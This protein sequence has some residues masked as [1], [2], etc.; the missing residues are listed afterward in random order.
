M[1]CKDVNVPK[2]EVENNIKLNLMEIDCEYGG[3]G[4]SGRPIARFGICNVEP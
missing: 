3:G 2:E 4:G 1:L